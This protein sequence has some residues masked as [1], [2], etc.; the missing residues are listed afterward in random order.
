MV[1]HVNPLEIGPNESSI[2]M[3]VSPNLG[4]IN[5]VAAKAID[6]YGTFASAFQSKSPT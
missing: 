2:C 3:V 1:L 6:A 4:N 5:G